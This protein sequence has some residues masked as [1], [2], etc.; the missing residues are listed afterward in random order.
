MQRELKRGITVSDRSKTYNA[1]ID[2]FSRVAGESESMG[3][4]NRKDWEVFEIQRIV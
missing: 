3:K 1:K 4:G 2:M